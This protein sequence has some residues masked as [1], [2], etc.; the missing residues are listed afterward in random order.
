MPCEKVCI[1]LY[2]LQCT[3]VSFPPGHGQGVF[4]CFKFLTIW[5]MKQ[6]LTFFVIC[7]RLINELNI[8]SHVCT[9][10][11]SSFVNYQFCLCL[12]YSVW[13][14]EEMGHPEYK[15]NWRQRWM[16][17]T[18]GPWLCFFSLC[19]CGLSETGL[20]AGPFVYKHLLTGGPSAHRH[21][22]KF[23]NSEEQV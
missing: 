23:H 1:N 17:R 7:I 6:C 14:Y 8:F 11:I 2:S 22:C 13:M 15:E 5:Q 21:R 4:P 16:L 12:Y 18:P 20:V 19:T 9:F 10:W 3:K